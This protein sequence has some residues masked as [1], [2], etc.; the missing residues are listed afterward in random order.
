MEERVAASCLSG[1]GRPWLAARRGRD[2]AQWLLPA[3]W[4][5]VTAGEDG[6]RR[7]S[8]CNSAIL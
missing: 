1:D 4:D 2:A 5:G 8:P 7:R 3:W 6:S